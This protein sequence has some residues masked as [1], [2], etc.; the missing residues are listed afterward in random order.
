[1][2]G[3]GSSNDSERPW[4]LTRIPI[5][6]LEEMPLDIAA[7]EGPVWGLYRQLKQ[8]LCAMLRRLQATRDAYRVL[9]Q[10]LAE[11]PELPLKK[12]LSEQ[13]EQYMAVES[14]MDEEDRAI[15]SA[16]EDAPVEETTHNSANVVQ[17]GYSCQWARG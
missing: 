5:L 2:P 9:D 17:N 4:Y 8:E 1:M 3:R 11:V 14:V 10:V 13:I 15:E 16:I 6:P 7:G 12:Y